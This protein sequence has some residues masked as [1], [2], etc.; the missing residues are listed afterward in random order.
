MGVATLLQRPFLLSEKPYKTLFPIFITKNLKFVS[1]IP[2]RPIRG[3]EKRVHHFLPRDTIANGMW[4][5]SD[6][7]LI[8]NLGQRFSA[9]L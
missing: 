2:L 1:E 8:R 3:A 5:K 7:P 9:D 4:Q 6:I